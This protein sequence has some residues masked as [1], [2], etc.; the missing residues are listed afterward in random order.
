METLRMIFRDEK[1]PDG[2][3][4][5]A[6]SVLESDLCINGMALNY[7]SF[8]GMDEAPMRSVVDFILSQRMSDGGF[9]CRKNR[10]GAVHSSLHTTISAAE[11][12]IYEYRRAG[13]SYRID[14]MKSAEESCCEFILAHRLFKSDRTGRVINEKFRKMVWPA[15]WYY[16]FLR[17][18]DFFRYSGRDKDERMNDAL[19]LLVKKRRKDGLW[20]NQ[21][22][23]PGGVHFKME[24]AGKPGRWN[25]L[26]AMRVLETFGH[27]GYG[28]IS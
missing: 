9:N 5:P 16:D 7:A 6:G 19:D 14:E 23:H 8:F 24:E 12:G 26:R 13:Y 1:G 3:I 17:A 25:T 20:P 15:R 18:L 2:G 11:E 27:P 22:A 28:V 4:N 21:A 10:S